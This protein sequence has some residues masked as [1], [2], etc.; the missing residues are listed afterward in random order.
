MTGTPVQSSPV[1]TPIALPASRSTGRVHAAT[2]T[3]PKNLASSDPVAGDRRSTWRLRWASVA[4]VLAVGGIAGSVAAASSVAHNDARVSLEAFQSSSAQIASTL[5]LTIRQEE[6]LIISA[7]GFVAGNPTASNSQFGQWVTSVHALTRYPELAGFGH[8]ILVSAADLPAFSAHAI[9]DPAGPLSADG[10]FQVFPPGKRASYCLLVGQAGL[11]GTALPAGYDFCAGAGDVYSAIESGA[12]SYTPLKVGSGVQLTIMTPIYRD[13]VL[14]ATPA[15][16]LAAFLGWV[17]M[18]VT[19]KVLLDRALQ[20]HPRTAVTFTYNK[21]GSHATFTSGT[22]PRGATSVTT[23]L[24]NGW[25][26]TTSGAVAQEG[27]FADANALWLLIIG[28]VTSVLLGLLVFILGFGRQIA[29]RLVGERTSQLRHQA[30]HDA[31]TGLPNRALILDRIDQILARSRRNATM[32]AALYLDLDDFKNVNDTLG[33]ATGDRLLIAVAARLAGTLR[34]VDTIGRMG[35]DEFVVLIDGASLDVAP[36]LVAQRLLDV[37]SQPFE[38]EGAST[39]LLVSMSIGIA[40]M[41]ERSSAGE[42]LRDADVALYQAK[43]AGK[44][45]FEVFHPEMQTKISRRIDL[46]FDLRSA[47]ASGEFRL[48]YQPIYNLDDLTMV[49]VEALLRWDHPSLG[50]VPPDEFIPILEQTGQIRSVGRW[51]LRQACDQ[52]TTWHARGNDLDVSVNV[53]GRQLDDDGIIE[54]VRD[55]LR[56]S[57]LDPTSLII[58]VTETAL[59]HDTEATSLRLQAI[60]QLGVRIA[61][62]DFGTGY[63]SLAYLRQFPVDC[64]KID[65]MFTNAITAS[66]ESRALVGTLVQ[67]GKDLG[68]STLAEG[69]ETTDEMDLLREAHINQAQGFL[70]A[71]PLEAHNLEANLLV[72]TRPPA[73]W[74][75]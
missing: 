18:A 74:R 52:M 51:V 27:V 26:V 38:L 32:G 37:M 9:V 44:N 36:E 35:G 66:P 34:D 60:K 7:G 4:T 47:V 56:I 2:E 22:A 1:G 33:H 24:H 31:L 46:E 19:P 14:P 8:A 30:L 6:D 43:A 49:G 69:V 15:A 57:G 40:V 29:L 72:P 55:A 12:G 48:V 58:E 17:G 73:L 21:A 3:S 59:M 54:D 41:E 65:R 45:R 62:D 64:L 68:L 11:P 28:A 23:D 50:A 10:T 71:R 75:Q 39:P 25:T 5:Q 61:I 13:G 16:R 42:L 20:G 53:S 67:L 70:L 63:S